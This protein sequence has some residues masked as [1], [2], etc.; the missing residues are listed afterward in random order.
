MSAPGAYQPR[1]GRVYRRH[2][3]GLCF[4]GDALVYE[5]QRR[6]VPWA[7][8]AYMVVIVLLLVLALILT[9]R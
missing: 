6:H 4:R 8:I 7:H 3:H 2:R 9:V 1:S 5:R